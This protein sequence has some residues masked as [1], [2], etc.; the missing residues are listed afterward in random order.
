MS[1][2]RPV[3]FLARAALVALV[4]GLAAL[5]ATANTCQ[6][7]AAELAALPAGGSA[8]DNRLAA[9]YAAEARRVAGE[10]AALGCNRPRLFIFGD[11]A[12]P[13]CAGLR[14]RHAQMQAGASYYGPGAAG[15]GEARR[16]QLQGALLANNCHGRPATQEADRQGVLTAGLF[17]DGRA[18]RR[19]EIVI[20]P[21]G[22][23]DDEAPIAT[24]R[25][26]PASG[27]SVCVRLCDGYFFPLPAS[28][29]KA[30]EDGDELCQSL[31]PAS[32]TRV[33]FLPSREIDRAVGSDG[34][35]YQNLANAFRYRQ[36]YDPTCGC[37]K[38]GETWA[39]ALRAAESQI[40][41]RAGDIVVPGADPMAIIGGR[42]ET[43]ETRLRGD[44]PAGPPL[45]P[46]ARPEGPEPAPGDIPVV[47][48]ELR[49][50]TGRDGVRRVVRV[51]SPGLSPA[52]SGEAAARVPDQ[53]PRP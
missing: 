45:P 37:R 4:S 52:P 13:Q 53:T 22:D 31:C 50:F 17:D 43:I 15:A 33:F 9:R 46:E 3:R 34:E 49:E 36:S 51:V 1:P 11:S 38:P 7:I 44:G 27:R 2:F 18:S 35:S 12:P 5:P 48:G 47:E 6:R 29:G 24:R 30:R 8:R 23:D 28:A 25:A 21:D 32:E 16:R 19:R 41:P 39:E 20:R 10:L 40:R 14:Q 42:A 26:V